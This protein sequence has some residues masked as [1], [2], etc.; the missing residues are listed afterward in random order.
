MKKVFFFLTIL[1]GLML[2]SC[3][4]EPVQPKVSFKITVSD[5]TTSSAKVTV[6]PSDTQ[7][8][9]YFDILSA[10]YVDS[11]GSDSALAMDNI[12]YIESRVAYHQEKGDGFADTFVTWLWQGFGEEEWGFIPAGLDCVA[13]AFCVDTTTHTFYGDMYK[14]PFR[15]L[16]ESSDE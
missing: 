2:T 12:D 16:D 13:F 6:V 8:Y 15:T 10:S 14:V 1:C 5:I 11:L 3:H 9:Y 4:N 7:V